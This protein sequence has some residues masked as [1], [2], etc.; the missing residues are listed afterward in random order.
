MNARIDLT[1]RLLRRRLRRWAVLLRWQR[2]SLEGVPVLF[3]NSFPKS[4]THLLTQVLHGF[5]EIGP[6]VDSGLP[7]AV[8]F[9][10]ETGRQ[11]STDEILGDLR[12]L[13]PGDIAYGHMHA[14]PEVVG[15]LC[16]ERFAAYFI[17]RDPRDVVV[18]HVHYVTDIEPGHI[19]HT[20]YTQ[21]LT[22][23]D[24]RLRTS[25][26]GL[27]DS[28]VPFPDIYQRIEPYLV[29]LERREV[30]CLR[31]EDFIM[32]QEQALG[33]VFD[34][35]VERGFPA[36]LPRPE[37]IRS[38]AA[39]IDPR[40]SPTF[41]SGKVGGWRDQFSPENKGIFKEVTGNLLQRLGYEPGNDW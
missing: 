16:G 4:G 13:L 9:I 17:L 30:L 32:D 10:G 31:Y 5:P 6:A 21:V 36:R 20:Y 2:L 27:P 12:R 11:R 34:H 23:F 28:E 33:S 38:L 3:A 22:D 41:R 35:A 18:S 40:R 24:Q 7:A 26:L 1:A 25:I 8:T 15:E 19:H 29:W 14:L 39:S 37:A